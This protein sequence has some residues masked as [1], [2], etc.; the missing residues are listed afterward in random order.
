[1]LAFS[2]SILSL[3]FRGVYEIVSVALFKYL[4]C[5]PILFT[6]SYLFVRVADILKV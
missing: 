4:F 1:M 5:S 6:H 3:Y 2:I